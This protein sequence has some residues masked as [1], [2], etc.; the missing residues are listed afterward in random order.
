MVMPVVIEAFGS[1]LSDLD[2]TLLL[3]GLD[4]WIM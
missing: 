2:E 1:V 4:N 3:I